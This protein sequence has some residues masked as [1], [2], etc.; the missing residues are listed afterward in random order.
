M[1]HAVPICAAGRRGVDRPMPLGRW[2]SGSRSLT[3]S[4][5]PDPCCVQRRIVENTCGAVVAVSRG[6][7]VSRDD[8]SQLRSGSH[9]HA[10]PLSGISGLRRLIYH[11]LGSFGS[12][13]ILPLAID[14]RTSASLAAPRIRSPL[15]HRQFLS[16]ADIH[17]AQQNDVDRHQ[18]S[19]RYPRNRSRLRSSSA[20]RTASTAWRISLR[21]PAVSP[22]SLPSQR[23]GRKRR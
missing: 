14:V 15:A 18:W 8:G 1:V 21:R 20:A 12:T 10:D 11:G 22:S 23:S 16:P 13:T 17:G 9:H 5:R 6:G 4:P 3:P 7:G 2:T 19:R